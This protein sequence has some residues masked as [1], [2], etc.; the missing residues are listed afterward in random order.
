MCRKNVHFDAVVPQN[1]NQV[2]KPNITPAYPRPVSVEFQHKQSVHL[3]ILHLSPTSWEL[4]EDY[5][6]L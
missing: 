3:N 5:F 1:N 6:S 2:T 4:S